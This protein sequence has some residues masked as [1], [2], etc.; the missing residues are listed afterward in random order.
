[1]TPNRIYLFLD[2]SSVQ[3]QAGLWCD[4]RWLSIKSQESPALESIFSLVKDCLDE[5][6]LKLEQVG[7]FIH[8]EGPGSVLGIRLAAMAI[9]S[10]QAL[11]AWAD[12]ESLACRSLSLA[13][14]LISATEQPEEPFHIIAEARQTRWNLLTCPDGEIA[15]VEPEVIDALA[16]PIYHLRQRKSWHTP[17]ERAVPVLNDLSAHPELLASPGLLSPVE[18]PGLF[19]VNEATYRTWTPERHR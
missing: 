11:P 8:C 10:W 9:R 18:A 4:S 3:V 16:A 14:A 1:M 19:L 2:A 13:A 15:E 5:A 7:G 6:N 17:P 12:A